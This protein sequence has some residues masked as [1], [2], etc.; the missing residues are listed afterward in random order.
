MEVKTD[1]LLQHGKQCSHNLW[2]QLPWDTG[3]IDSSTSA[4]GT[5]AEVRDSHLEEAGFLSGFRAV[6]G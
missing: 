1:H 6:L 3:V 5:E 2:T 4:P